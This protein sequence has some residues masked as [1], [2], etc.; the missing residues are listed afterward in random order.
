[1]ADHQQRA[2]S[3]PDHPGP[4]RVAITV[5]A[6]E[7][8]EMQPVEIPCAV[9]AWAALIAAWWHADD[10]STHAVSDLGR[11]LSTDATKSLD[12]IGHG[13]SP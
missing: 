8:I 7:T 6:P 3:R 4:A 1:M 13:E 5:A 9:Q 2:A 12:N 11:R 10:R